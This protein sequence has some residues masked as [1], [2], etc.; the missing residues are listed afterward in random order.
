MR[1][2]EAEIDEIPFEEH[3][4]LIT[5]PAAEMAIYHEQEA[6]YSLIYLLGEGLADLSSRTNSPS[7]TP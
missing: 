7:P 1:K 2:N 4:Q 6:R 5:L 3:V